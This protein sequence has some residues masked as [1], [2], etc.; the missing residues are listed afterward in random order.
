M[1]D[2]LN[3]GWMRLQSPK[4][5]A[6]QNPAITTYSLPTKVDLYVRAI[7][8]PLAWTSHKLRFTRITAKLSNTFQ[9]FSSVQPSFLPFPHHRRQFSRIESHPKI[10]PRI[11]LSTPH[12]RH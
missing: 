6:E 7:T 9:Q 4:N 12:S 8:I 10:F 11:T 5:F 1:E 3:S 2:V